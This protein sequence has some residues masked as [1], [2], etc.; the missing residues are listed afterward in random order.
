MLKKLRSDNC[1]FQNEKDFRVALKRTK[2]QSFPFFKV[3]MQFLS[4]FKKIPWN[5]MMKTFEKVQIRFLVVFYEEI[6]A[7]FD[8]ISQTDTERKNSKISNF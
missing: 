1:C 6:I 8:M 7:V 4:K 5:G 2:T 3:F